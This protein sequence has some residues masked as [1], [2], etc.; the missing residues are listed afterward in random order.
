MIY[1]LYDALKGRWTDYYAPSSHSALMAARVSIAYNIAD[2]VYLIF[3]F[4]YYVFLIHH[5]LVMLIVIPF[6]LQ[7]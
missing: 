4:P 7:V 6:A 2:T 3:Y 5:P 1:F